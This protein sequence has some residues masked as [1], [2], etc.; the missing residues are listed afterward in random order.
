MSYVISLSN[1]KGGVA[2]TTSCIALGSSLVEIGYKVLL[3]DLDPNANLTLGLKSIPDQPNGSSKDLFLLGHA[4]T[5]K[6]TKTSYENLDIIP[7]NH[8]IASLEARSLSLN[9]SAMLL[10]LALNALPSGPYDFIVIDCP[11]SLGFL[12]T[13]ALAA[14]DLLIIPT[15]PE[16][17]SAHALQTMLTVVR[18]IRKDKN[19][20]LKYKILITLLD[21]RLKEHAK[22]ADQFQNHIGGSLFETR[23][24][25]DTRFKE[26]QTHGVPITYY[27]PKS[28]G[29]LQYKNL[30][31][32]I[33]DNIK[34]EGNGHYNQFV[35]DSQPKSILVG[36]EHTQK[37]Y[38]SAS[39]N[40]QMELPYPQDQI[41][42]TGEQINS[43]KVYENIESVPP[44]KSQQAEQPIGIEKSCPF[45][46]GFD[47]PQTKLSYPSSWNKCHRSKPIFSPNLTHQTTNC[48]SVK[49]RSCLMLVDK[50]HKSL[51][52]NLRSPSEKSEF[53]Q[54]LKNWVRTIVR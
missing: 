27:V 35:V 14:S 43:Q 24:Q 22:A 32:E 4:P 40:S 20:A 34:I 37:N 5:L 30:A 52:A 39:Y 15:Q 47:N 25:I 2:K 6:S 42:S 23:I 33:V 12:T 10:K 1:V 17:F 26:S 53:L 18:D 49:H 13:N 19:P 36:A 29:A 51:P 46:G 21:L 7:S 16:I 3:I 41:L 8:D 50:A 38:P 45:L 48:L 28:R 44:A 31:Q 54:Y 11:P 9:N